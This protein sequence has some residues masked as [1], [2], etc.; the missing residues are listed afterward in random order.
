[1]AIGDGPPDLYA[2][3]EVDGNDVAYT[4]TFLNTR[5]AIWDQSTDL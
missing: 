5:N 2:V 1:M 4:T 3:L